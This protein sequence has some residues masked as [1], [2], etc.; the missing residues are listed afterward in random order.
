MTI[1]LD[2]LTILDISNNSL[3]CSLS[4]LSKLPKLTK[5]CA[6]NNSIEV[7]D[8]SSNS[9]EFLDLSNNEICEFPSYSK[10]PNL[11][12][13]VINYNKIKNFQNDEFRSLISLY[14]AG[15]EINSIPYSSQFPNL[16][17]L[18]ISENP[19]QN[20]P[21]D[22]RILYQ[23]PK[24]KML[25]GLIMKNQTHSK[26]KNSFNGILFPEDLP[27]ILN[28]DQ[29]QL[30]LSEKE[31][32]DVNSIESKSLQ[33]LIL[34]H[35]LLKSINWKPN[36]LPKLFELYLASNELQSF[37]FL[38]LVPNIK[39]LDLSFNKLNDDSLR[40]IVSFKLNRLVQLNLSNNSFRNLPIISSSFP[41]LDRLDVSHNFILAVA[42]GSFEG[43]KIVDLSYNS[44]QKLDNVGA[45]SILALDISHNRVNNVD[46]VYKISIKCTNIEKF[47]FH[48]NPLGQR[49][50]PRIKCLAYLRTLKEMDGRPVTETD[51][52]QV[53]ILI[54]QGTNS[55][56]STAVG[57][58]S[59]GAAGSSL[60]GPPGRGT[61][62][63]NVN[64]GF[65]LP[66]LQN[67]QQPRKRGKK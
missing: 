66:A 29:I 42:P 21:T 56:N 44:M 5:L 48:D 55:P 46:E 6:S 54:D 47:A 63:N 12:T 53:K 32:S 37:E 64:L 1:K 19:L 13:L 52:Q 61:R 23:F 31:Y 30:D 38:G 60:M 67:P 28:P 50:S 17:I 26:A 34:N 59:G 43:V 18:F 3:C 35:N 33:K 62:I 9:L 40:S 7:I 65:G 2:Q 22:L 25:N 49:V 51:L 14:V 36:S 10:F 15:N 8:F 24:L 16:C 27:L 20:S 57:G 39:V 45:N 4:P 11:E 41:S 58:A